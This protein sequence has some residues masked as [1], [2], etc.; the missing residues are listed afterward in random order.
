MTTIDIVKKTRTAWR[1]LGNADTEA[2]N[3]VLLSMADALVKNSAAIIKE[4][5]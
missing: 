2:K 1:T 3:K 5:Q 4:N